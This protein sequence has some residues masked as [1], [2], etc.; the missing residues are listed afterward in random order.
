MPHEMPFQLWSPSLFPPRWKWAIRTPPGWLREREAQRLCAVLLEDGA[1]D[2][3]GPI[4]LLQLPRAQ[5]GLP[6]QLSV[7]SFLLSGCHTASSCHHRDI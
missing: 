3:R 2:N 5:A 4:Q 1:G 7:L 6:S